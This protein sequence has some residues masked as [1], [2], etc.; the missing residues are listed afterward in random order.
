MISGIVLDQWF[1]LEATPEDL[2]LQF[3][4]NNTSNYST[5]S[6]KNIGI[7]RS[8]WVTNNGEIEVFMGQRLAKNLKR[9][10]N[11]NIFYYE[12]LLFQINS[13]KYQVWNSILRP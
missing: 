8:I 4:E 13:Q 9:L 2:C 11:T 10:K 12:S 5:F 1:F 3:R 7:I 6:G